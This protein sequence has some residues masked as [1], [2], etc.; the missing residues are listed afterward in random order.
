MKK[1]RQMYFFIVSELTT[2]PQFTTERAIS[3]LRLPTYIIHEILDTIVHRNPV[4]YLFTLIM[5]FA[6][7]YK[8]RKKGSFY[9]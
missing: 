5:R 3:N 1:R 4:T 9:N 7:A 8:S 6:F 2:G